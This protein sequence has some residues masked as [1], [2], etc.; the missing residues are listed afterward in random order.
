MR[1]N[2]GGFLFDYYVDEVAGKGLGVFA[3]EP[4]KQGSVV[5]RHCS[6]VFRVFDEPAFRECI[7]AMSPEDVV[8]E[9]THVHAFEDF[10]G[11]L[12]RALDDGIFINHCDAPTLV[13]NYETPAGHRLDCRASDYLQRVAAALLDDRYSLMAARAIAVGEELTNDYNLDDDCP[14]YHDALCAQYGVT[15]EYLDGIS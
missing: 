13:A 3:A 5:W 6:G 2:R 14:H 1:R 4:I 9:L 11:C 8:Y 12:V 10:P 7:S 15:E